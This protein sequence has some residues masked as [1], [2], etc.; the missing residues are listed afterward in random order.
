MR[1]IAVLAA[2]L[3]A[4]A[5]PLPAQVSVRVGGLRARY[6]GGA[7]A[8]AVALA[9][10][11]DWASGPAS[12]NLELSY[13]QFTTGGWAAQMSGGAATSRPLGGGFA[14]GLLASA[15]GSWLQYGTWS[16]QG[17][18]GLA[19]GRRLG[20]FV[21]SLGAS[22]GL[23]R[24]I[25]D[26]VRG[27]AI[28]LGAISTRAIGFDA[29]LR[30]QRAATGPSHWTDLDAHVVRKV[31]RVTFDVGGGMRRFDGTA[32]AQG[33]WH[34]ASTVELGR[35]VVL[36]AAIGAYPRSPDGFSEGRY[37]TAGFRFI[38]APRRETVII[39]P[40]SAG[41][42]RVRFVVRGASRVAIAG[43][44]NAW[45]P[46]PL[47]R[48]AAGR[49]SAELPLAVGAHKFVLVV[50]DGRQVVPRGVPTLPD[51]FGGLVGL[52]VI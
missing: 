10:R 23:V 27:L 33:V 3:L 4:L 43:D 51:G 52:L 47:A 19:L 18:A 9:P 22:A 30:A 41:R 40:V 2:A 46:T 1:R 14:L 49:W 31:D 36:D 11:I 39:E 25:T 38:A 44:W 15:N 7:E 34:A 42:V 21:A 29:A 48:D 8:T 12:G 26:T 17:Q 32:G 24:S 6:A 28:V 20:P 50:D 37:V 16:A 13:A 5:H 35:N 45:S